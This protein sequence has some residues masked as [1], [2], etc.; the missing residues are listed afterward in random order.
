MG[1]DEPNSSADES[2]GKRHGGKHGDDS[3]EEGE[4][5]DDGVELKPSLRIRNLPSPERDQDDSTVASKSSVLLRRI[6]E[7]S[8]ETKKTR[9]VTLK[10]KKEI[11]LEDIQME[12]ISSDEDEKE[13]TNEEQ[14]PQEESKT[15]KEPVQ[16]PETVPVIAKEESES[17]KKENNLDDSIKSENSIKENEVGKKTRQKL[18][19][20]NE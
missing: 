1:Y 20:K 6:P 16:V 5:N 13:E 14:Q 4:C 17:D 9:K 18:K 15:D 19:K 2:K 10:K 8:P 12:Q 3:A 11:S 7:D